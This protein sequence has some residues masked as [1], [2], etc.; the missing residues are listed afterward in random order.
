V[1]VYHFELPYLLDLDILSFDQLLT[2]CREV[3]DQKLLEQAVAMRYA[4]NADQKQFKEF[5]KAYSHSNSESP[6]TEQDL[7]RNLTKL[8][9][10]FGG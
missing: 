8:K 10:V 4:M 7:H 2:L 1:T 3:A 6:Q 5:Q 9:R